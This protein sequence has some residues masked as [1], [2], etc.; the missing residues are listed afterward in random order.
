MA[1]LIITVVGWGT[2]GYTKGK[3]YGLGGYGF[4]RAMFGVLGMKRLNSAIAAKQRE[5]R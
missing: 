1:I 4:K 5:A 3:P 2:Y